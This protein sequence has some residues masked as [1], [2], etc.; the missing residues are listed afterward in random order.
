MKEIKEFLDK[1]LSDFDNFKYNLEK[2]DE[3]NYVIFT[4]IFGENCNKE[5]TFKEINDVLYIHSTSFGWKAIKKPTMNKFLWIEL[6][7]D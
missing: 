2:E 5:V 1:E 3:Y 7:R 6:L 4:Q